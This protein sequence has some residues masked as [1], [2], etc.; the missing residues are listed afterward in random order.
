[1]MLDTHVLVW[2]RDKNVTMFIRLKGHQPPPLY[3]YRKYNQNYYSLMRISG[4][5][6][7]LIDF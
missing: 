2:D 3:I 4:Q 6:V 1:M 5:V 7:R